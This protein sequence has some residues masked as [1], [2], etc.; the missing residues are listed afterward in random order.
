M[1][2]TDN[3]HQDVESTNE[4]HAS[5]P[6]EQEMV[7]ELDEDASPAQIIDILLKNPEVLIR[8]I[9]SNQ[10]GRNILILAAIA[11]GCHLIYGLIV[12]SFSG[13]SQWY[14]APMKI[15]FGTAISALLCFPSLYIF[16][17]LSGASISPTQALA[18]VSSGLTLTAILLL[19]FAPVAFVFTFSI[20]TLF[21]M[22]AVHLLVWGISIYFGLRYIYQ[23]LKSMSCKNNDLIKVWGVILIIT[24]LQMTTTLRPIIGTSDQILTAEKR[25][26]VEH[27]FDNGSNMQQAQTTLPTR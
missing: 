24:M 27:W 20:K 14:A 16:A 4:E 26:F 3:K 25:S 5:L 21:F 15:I 22:G 8:Q 6:L 12:G 7:I 9:M 18:M 10:A 13:D 19:G 2:T 23:G 1:T 17:C 11:V